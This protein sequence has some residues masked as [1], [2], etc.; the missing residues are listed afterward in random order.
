[1][2]NDGGF[3]WF[4]IAVGWLAWIFS[5]DSCTNGIWYGV[6][7]QLQAGLHKQQTVQL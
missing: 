3:V 4:L 2:S 1:M 5:P 6:K 7:Y